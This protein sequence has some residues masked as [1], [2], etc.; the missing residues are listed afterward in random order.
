MTRSAGHDE[1]P[2]TCQQ[3][4]LLMVPVWVEDLGLTSR[5][6]SDFESHL[7]GCPACRAEWEDTRSLMPL[8][9]TA[10]AQAGQDSTGQLQDGGDQA[11][12][13]REED[14]AAERF[15]RPMSVEEGWEDLQRR[16]PSLAQACQRM[17]RK[18]Q[19][20]QLTWRVG[21]VAAA[22][23]VLAAVGVGWRMLS[24]HSS[25][26]PAAGV[27]DRAV[28]PSPAPL[29]E[30]VTPRGLAPLALNRPVTADERPQELL[31]AGLHRVVMN[32]QT[33]VTV[34]AAPAKAPGGKAAFEIQ[35]ARGE[36]YVEVVPGHPFT[37]KTGNARLDI[38]GTRF[39]VRADGDKTE[40]TL[41]KG[42]IRFSQPA[43]AGQFV[44]V[45]A[46]QASALVG[47]SA[48]SA[49]QPADALAAT[50]WARDLALTNAIARAQPDADLALLDPV[51]DSWPQSRPLDLNSIDYAKW[52]DERRDWF[53]R[54]FPWIFK[55]QKALKDRH[56]LDV[57]YIELLM[58]SGDIWQFHYPRRWNQP[59]PVLNPSSLKQIAAHY[60]VDPADLLE[61]VG[62]SAASQANNLPLAEAAKQY[63]SALQRWQSE[64]AGLDGPAGGQPTDNQ[65]SDV[66][67]F[68][69]RAGTYL[70]NT[71]TA[72]WAWAHSHPKQASAL[73]ATWKQPGAA[74]LNSETPNTP[75]QWLGSLSDAASAA[76]RIS[77]VAPELLKI[78]RA[79]G[80]GAAAGYSLRTELRKDVAAMLLAGGAP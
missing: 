22:A 45:P 23:C 12:R 68:T 13:A 14:D 37:V 32:T 52:R 2:M 1:A 16:S 38:T 9:R 10:G 27:A 41:L 49:P 5:Q 43:R 33:S 31:L 8:V 62:P 70:A 3:A 51:R 6:R 46:G 4:Q 20:R 74:L 34:S 29:I 25:N 17:E 67:M 24:S 79:S 48:P 18:R 59:I 73:L 77:Q 65:R 54:E 57:D 53:A 50:A 7:A 39:D 61:A 36:L 63:R 40:L 69:F 11:V 76:S 71:R 35:L 66:L 72:A 21:A 58:V 64:I 47:R 44:D 80:C 26:A 42:S 15:G 55:I 78:P 28:A 19:R 60:A 75:Q 30:L 56:G